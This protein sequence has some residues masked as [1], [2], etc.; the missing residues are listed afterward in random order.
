MGASRSQDRAAVP[1]RP[2]VLRHR[3]IA[4]ERRLR[5]DHFE[6]HNAQGINIHAGV[7]ILT[8]NLFRRHVKRRPDNRS[9]RGLNFATDNLGN[10]K[11]HQD[12]MALLV[13]HDIRRLDVTVDHLSLMRIM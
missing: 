9:G 13:E 8:L 12:G 1:R 10:A 3:R 4:A 5:C 11:V 7:R 6:K 2:T